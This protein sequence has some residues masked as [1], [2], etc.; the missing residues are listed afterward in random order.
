MI[1]SL[2]SSGSSITFAPR[3][4]RRLGGGPS[5]IRLLP[6]T[7]ASEPCSRSSGVIG[8]IDKVP[9]IGDWKMMPR[10]LAGFHR[11]AFPL[12]PALPPQAD[13]AGAE[14]DPPVPDGRRRSQGFEPEA[15]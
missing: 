14:R 6:M 4:S 3:I 12:L 1:L 13:R 11:F 5:G 2:P 10:D 9:G 7:S 8:E 15:T